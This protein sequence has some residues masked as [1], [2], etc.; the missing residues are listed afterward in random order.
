MDNGQY[1]NSYERRNMDQHLIL[2]NRRYR[3]CDLGEGECTLMITAVSYL[4]SLTDFYLPRCNK[5]L[6]VLDMSESWPLNT[7]VVNQIEAV[8]LI[9]DI[10]LLLDIYWLEDVEIVLES[11]IQDMVPSIIKSL[12]GRITRGIYQAK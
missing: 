11:P 10:C 12:E 7:D 4:D 1:V 8:Q 6:I 9:D 2:N 5:R 3:I